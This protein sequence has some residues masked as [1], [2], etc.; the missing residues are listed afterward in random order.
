MANASCAS[1]RAA[2]G[3]CRAP[4]VAR[5]RA[6]LDE[7]ARSGRAVAPPSSGCSRTL[8]PGSS[9]GW[10]AATPT[11]WHGRAGAPPG[12]SRISPGSEP[13][14]EIAEAVASCSVA[15]ATAR[16]V[17]GRSLSPPQRRGAWRDRIEA[18]SIAVC[19]P[20]SSSVPSG[21]ERGA[22]GVQAWLGSFHSTVATRRWVRSTQ[23]TPGAECFRRRRARSQRRGPSPSRAVP[24]T[25]PSGPAFARFS[26][27]LR[28]GSR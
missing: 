10:A 21:Q 3:S 15:S 24:A 19:A 23:G 14:G 2:S 6:D 17:S 25:Y 11:N 8:R 27:G 7:V 26:A 16:P 1:R 12:C 20:A 9:R 22:L 5:R 13:L 28:P 4:S 18:A